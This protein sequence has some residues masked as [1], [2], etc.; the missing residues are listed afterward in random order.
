MREPADPMSVPG[1]GAQLFPLYDLAVERFDSGS[2]FVEVG[3]FL[4]MSAC[5]GAQ[6]IKQSGK[7]IRLTCVDLWKEMDDW[8]MNDS[9]EIWSSP[10]PELKRMLQKARAYVEEQ[11]ADGLCH[12][13]F[14]RTLQRCGVADIIE[15]L[16]M[17]S[18]EAGRLYPRG[19]IDFVLVDADHSYQECGVIWNLGARKSKREA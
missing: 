8:V 17:S 16:H 19:A 10:V 6:R 11:S 18:E 14:A 7:K 5:Y 15:P 12:E 3:S 13:A 4:G 1:W 2:H 9:H